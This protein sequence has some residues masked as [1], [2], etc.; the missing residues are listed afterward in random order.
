MVDRNKVPLR[1]V[2]LYVGLN[3]PL[4][5]ICA[6]LSSFRAPFAADIRPAPQAAVKAKEPKVVTKHVTSTSRS[7]GRS[8]SSTRQA[9]AGGSPEHARNSNQTPDNVLAVAYRTSSGERPVTG[10]RPSARR[11]GADEYRME[12]AEVLCHPA[13]SSGFGPGVGTGRHRNRRGIRPPLA[14]GARY[15]RGRGWL[16]RGRYPTAGRGGMMVDW[17]F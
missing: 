6:C 14:R 17:R 12:A 15:R 5:H 10:Y 16:T 7:R 4:R 13:R 3:C 11:R 8:V 2:G 1:R 9:E